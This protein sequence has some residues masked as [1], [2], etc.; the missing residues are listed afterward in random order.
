M[1][2]AETRA[3][4]SI[5]IETRCR[6]LTNSGCK[7]GKSKP[8]SCDLYPLSYD[9]DERQFLFDKECPLLDTYV[10]QLTDQHSDASRHLARMTTA[11]RELERSDQAFLARNYAIDSDY[12]DLQPIGRPID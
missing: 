9:P 6:N 2:A 3:M 4:G 12:F 11:I 1:T 10:S 7:L 8:L 5:C